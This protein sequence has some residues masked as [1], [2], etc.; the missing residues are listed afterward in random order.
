MIIE[1]FLF[2]LTTGVIVNRLIINSIQKILLMKNIG[3]H[4]AVIYGANRRGID[5]YNTLKNHSHHGINVI[6]FIKSDSDK[7]NVL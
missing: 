3:L 7:G 6:G 1:I 4:R 2:I 5:V